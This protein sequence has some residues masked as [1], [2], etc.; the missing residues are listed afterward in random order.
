MLFIHDYCVSQE[1]HSSDFHRYNLAVRI[2]SQVSLSQY[3]IFVM[4]SQHFCVDRMRTQPLDDKDLYLIKLVIIMCYDQ[5]N[6]TL[7][8]M[9]FKEHISSKG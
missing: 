2:P 7:R 4:S 5:L 9:F 6:S 8:L 3:S 1:L